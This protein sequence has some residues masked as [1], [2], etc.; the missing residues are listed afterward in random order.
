MFQNK[1]E[2]LG[3]FG[4]VLAAAACP[5]CFPKLAMLGTVFGLGILAPFE[6]VFFYGSQLLVLLALLGHIVSFK[7]HKNRGILGLSLVSSLLL[8][9]SLWLI[10]VELLSYLSFGG[11]IVA[12]LWL[13]LDI[14]RSCAEQQTNTN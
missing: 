8:F 2:K 10:R 14:R 11:L 7:T 13:T 5:I 6:T 9:S 4:A 12:T 3:S 1:L